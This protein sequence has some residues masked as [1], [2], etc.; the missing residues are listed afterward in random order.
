MTIMAKAKKS[1]FGPQIAIQFYKNPKL[2][3]IVE[4]HGAFV[5]QVLILIFFVDAFNL[6]IPVGTPMC[7]S[8]LYI[9]IDCSISFVIS[10]T[11]V[12]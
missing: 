10:C 6:G 11:S 2:R 12:V 3:S 1:I 8:L 9:P 7:L 5:S 4:L